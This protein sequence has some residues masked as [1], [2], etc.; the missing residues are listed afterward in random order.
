MPVVS[1]D[2][3]SSDLRTRFSTFWGSATP[4]ASEN[5]DFDPQ[6]VFSVDPA[7][8]ADSD[9]DAYVRVLVQPTAGADVSR[10]INAAGTYQETAVV[11][12]EIFVREGRSTAG[13]DGHVTQI[14]RFLRGSPSEHA[15]VTGL[16]ALTVGPNGVWFQRNVTAVLRW[17]TD[18]PAS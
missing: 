2:D 5:D 6:A 13:V 1:L 4:I 17:W 11:A 12:F 8:P 9:D 7:A 3:V 15:I 16:S 10:S 14:K 18:Q